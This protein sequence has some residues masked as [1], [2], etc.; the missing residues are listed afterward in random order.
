MGRTLGGLA[1]TALL[2]TGCG[3][4]AAPPMAV[5]VSIRNVSPGPVVVDIS[6]APSGTQKYTIQPWQKGKCFAHLAFDPGNVEI[7]VSGSNVQPERIYSVQ[8][9]GNEAIQ[10]GVQVFANGQVQ[11]GGDFPADTLPCAG[12]G[13]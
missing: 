11:F 2:T 13:Y 12:G 8:V 5:Q 7:R 10:I 9:S 3:F 6:A 4:R 1:V